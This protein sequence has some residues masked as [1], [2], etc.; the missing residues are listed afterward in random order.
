MK[1]HVTEMF[2]ID[3]PIFAFS[4]CRDVGAAVTKAGGLASQVRG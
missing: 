1:N 3:I 4:H 2:G